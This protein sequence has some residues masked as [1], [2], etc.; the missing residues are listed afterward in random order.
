[1]ANYING[2]DLCLYIKSGSTFKCIAQAT[3]CE[4]DVKMETTKVK[5]KD[6]V[7]YFPTLIRGD[8]SWSVSTN[9]LFTQDVLGTSG[10]SYDDLMDL[11]LNATVC[12]ISLGKVSTNGMGWPQS[13]GTN[14]NLTGNVL[15][16]DIKISS[17][18]GEPATYSVS[19]DGTGPIT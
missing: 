8:Y 14:K 7:G 4:I 2:T 19:M 9:H 5:T 1:M 12:T 15:I 18:A 17:K 6:E 13:I 3:D 10:Y 11:E 16:T